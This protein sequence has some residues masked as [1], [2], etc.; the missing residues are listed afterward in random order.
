MRRR[1]SALVV[2]GFLG[3]T[4]GVAAPAW[5]DDE[6]NGRC[7]PDAVAVGPVCVDKYEA[8]VWQVPPANTK[9]IRKI[10]AG[11]VT[12]AELTAGGATQVSPSSSCRPAFPGTFPDTGNWTAPLY[13]VSIP[14]VHPTAC[15]TWF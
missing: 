14:G 11:T 2:I 3:V 7:A 4:V 13:A 5:A 6:S 15:V 1:C 12:L 8:S 10:N 9:L